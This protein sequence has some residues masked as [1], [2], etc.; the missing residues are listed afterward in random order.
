M[1][2][3]K[4]H[5]H[6]LGF[7]PQPNLRYCYNKLQKMSRLMKSSV[8]FIAI[9]ALITL[10]PIVQANGEEVAEEIRLRLSTQ[11]DAAT[12]KP[13]PTQRAPNRRIK[14]LNKRRISDRAPRQRNPQLSSRHLMLIGFDA[15]E[16]E[17]TR[18][19][20]VDPRLIRAEIFDNSGEIERSVVIY[21]NDVEFS[22]VVPQ[23][24]R[25]RKLKIYHPR[26]TGDAYNL[27]II[28]E[29]SLP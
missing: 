9:F 25:I 27:E 6:M 29:T 12:R 21:R 18:Q 10:I 28:G 17:V 13:Y 20:I 15:M 23:S 11:I 2:A 7:V 14:I 19:M 8:L 16:K 1:K 3:T 4:R 26:W 24:P 22:I 5:S